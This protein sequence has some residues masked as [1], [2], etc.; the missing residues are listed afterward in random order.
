MKAVLGLLIALGVLVGYLCFW[1][2]AVDPVAWSAPTAPP[3]EGPFQ[4]NEALTGAQIV[5][6]PNARG[7]EDVAVD[8]EGRIYVG[9]LEGAI[10][11]YQDNATQPEVFV[12]TGGRPLG[13]DFDR[14]GNLIVADA[15]RGLLSIDPTG[16]MTVLCNEVDG[17]PLVFVDDVEVAPDGK[18]YFSD[19]SSR[20]GYMQWVQDVIESRPNGQLLVYDPATKRARTVIGELH[21]ANGVAVAPDGSFVLVNETTRYRTLRH[22]LK[23]KK[24]GTTEVFI[25]NLPGFPDGISRGQHGLFWLAF[26]APRDEVIDR[27]SGNPFARRVIARLPNALRPQP[28][29]HP[30]VIGLDANGGVVHN[31]QDASGKSF[32]ATTSVQEH[33]GWLYIGSLHEPAWARYPAPEG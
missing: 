32:A 6:T 31:F 22:W 13:L 20:F 15:V 29:R 25:D 1:P 33:D 23:G 28:K 7:P 17:R 10:L 19:A 24:A 8:A 27:T 16:V 30:F 4:A 2:V 21:F 3:L 12:Q 9:M 5:A 14:A 11:R 18:I 26:A